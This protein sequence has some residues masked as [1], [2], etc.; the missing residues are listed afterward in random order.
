M[1]WRL[2]KDGWFPFKERIGSPYRSGYTIPLWVSGIKAAMT[3]YL[4]SSLI[5]CENKS[6]YKKRGWGGLQS[7]ELRF[8]KRM[9]TRDLY[10]S[11]VGGFP[12]QWELERCGLNGDSCVGADTTAPAY[13]SGFMFADAGCVCHP[14]ATPLSTVLFKYIWPLPITH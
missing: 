12:R 3:N 14:L 6:L 5:K 4:K 1:L 8:H 10:S 2:Q 11:H 13:S 7:L 9:N